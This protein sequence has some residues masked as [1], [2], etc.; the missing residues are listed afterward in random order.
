[1]GP[2]IWAA[3]SSPIFEY[4]CKQGYG[5][6]FS[7]SI[8]QK[9]THVVGFGFVDDVDLLAANDSMEQTQKQVVHSLQGY[10]DNWELGLWVSGGHYQP[11]KAI[12]H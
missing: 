1:M 10:L 7:A 3:I 2:Q 4:V 9:H 6:K 8:S 12:G 5:A 11:I